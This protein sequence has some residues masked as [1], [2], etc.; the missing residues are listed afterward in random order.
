MCNDIDTHENAQNV[1]TR[2]QQFAHIKYLLYDMLVIVIHLQL[3]LVYQGLS[4][5]KLVSFEKYTCV[6]VK[7]ELSCTIV[8]IL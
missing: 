4:H 7:F 6:S 5:V 1:L 2:E 8:C 3:T